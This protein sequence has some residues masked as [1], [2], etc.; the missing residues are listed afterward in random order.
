MRLV[1][2]S[3][4]GVLALAA[5]IYL[6][7]GA[8]IYAQQRALL[9]RPNP[10]R[11]SPSAAGLAQADEVSLNPAGAPRLVAWRI[12]AADATRPVILYL[13]GNAGNLARRSSRFRDLTRQGAGLLA[14]SWR[15]Y[16]GSEGQPS[17]AGFREDAAAA[18]AFLRREGIQPERIVI[19]G[20]S[21]GS[22]VAVM[23]AAEL[24]VRALVLDSPY[25]S[26]AAIAAERYWWLP[27]NLLIRDPF[28]A[29]AAAPRVR[30]PALALACTDDWLT[31]HDG[32]KRLVEALGGRKRLITFDRRCHI[33]G[34]AGAGEQIAAFVADPSRL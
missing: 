12:P 23:L 14:V 10:E 5:M 18:V 21:L 16:G 32:A 25:E 9:F 33:P 6:G 34:L 3:F 28:R 27:V 17:E 7:F 31:P 22:G 11:V 8:T 29:I 20:E 30:A 24:P 13:H 1:K 15:G 26:I 19:F 2:R 4:A